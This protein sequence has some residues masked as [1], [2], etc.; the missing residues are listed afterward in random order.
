MLS[1]T[2]HL[3]SKIHPH[4]LL[5][6]ISAV[7]KDAFQDSNTWDKINGQTRHQAGFMSSSQSGLSSIQA[8]IEF[9]RDIEYGM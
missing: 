2:N 3:N 6:S 4:H 5:Q 1:H 8:V 7:V 9:D